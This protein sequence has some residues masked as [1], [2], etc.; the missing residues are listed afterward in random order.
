MIKLWRNHPKII[1]GLLLI[2]PC[3]VMVLLAP[4]I[5]RHDPETMDLF[6]VCLGPSREHLFGTDELGRDL[7]SRI[8]H[9]GRI[10]FGIA[11]LAL[12]IS[13]PAGITLGLISGY[14]GGI[15]DTLIMRAIDVYLAF[16][17]ILFAVLITA[18]IGRGTL[19]LILA[20]SLYPIPT[21]ARLVRGSVL[22]VKE[23]GY[24]KAARALGCSDLHIVVRHIMPNILAPV[25][26]QTSLTIAALVLLASSLGFLG[27]GVQPPTPEWGAILSRGRSY[28]SN[29]PH[30]CI[31]PGVAISVVVFGFSLLGDGLRDYMDPRLRKSQSRRSQRQESSVQS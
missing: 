12:A 29:A 21:F 27:L 20:L 28:L 4:W 11:A 5:A 15:C 6:A 16:P 23:R 22:T 26:V 17:G 14:C 24:V 19:A 7:F 31:F 25:I 8:L 30:M 10:S 1:M 13:A 9:G 3:F 2:C 18:I